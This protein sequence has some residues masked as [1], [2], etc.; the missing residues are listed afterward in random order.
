MTRGRESAGF[1]DGDRA[2]AL[3]P[4]GRAAVL[5]VGGGG[6]ALQAEAKAERGE[7]PSWM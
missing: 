2:G 3:T 7:R 1:T 4:E 6:R 5:P